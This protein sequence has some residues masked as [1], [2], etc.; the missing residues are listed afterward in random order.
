MAIRIITGEETICVNYWWELEAECEEIKSPVFEVTDNETRESKWKFSLRSEEDKLL[1]DFD[2]SSASASVIQYSFYVCDGEKKEEKLSVHRGWGSGDLIRRQCLLVR[3]NFWDKLRIFSEIICKFNVGKDE[4]DIPECQLIDELNILF[5]LKSRKEKNPLMELNWGK[6]F[7]EYVGNNSGD[8]KMSGDFTCNGEEVL[9]S[10]DNLEVN[11]SECEDSICT[12]NNIDKPL[13]IFTLA[14]NSG[15]RAVEVYTVGF[16][17][18]NIDH[19]LAQLSLEDL[20]ADNPKLAVTLLRVALN[21]ID[22]FQR[23]LQ[24]LK[25]FLHLQ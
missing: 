15:L 13:E 3:N 14:E 6:L 4:P 23:R 24:S 20:E 1:I 8:M 22:E 21:K 10:S 11:L 17:E 12:Q 16:I 25:S 9:H 5:D 19:I 2:F 18:N 7:L